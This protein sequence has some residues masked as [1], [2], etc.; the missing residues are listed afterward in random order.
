MS[1]GVSLLEEAGSAAKG[2]SC[3][4]QILT[5]PSSEQD[6]TFLNTHNF[7][8]KGDFK[9]NNKKKKYIIAQENFF[10]IYI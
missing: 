1:G 5:L 3:N 10:Y 4:S 7:I 2:S 9:N 6:I 8:G